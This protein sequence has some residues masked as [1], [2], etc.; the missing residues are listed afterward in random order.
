MDIISK[1]LVDIKLQ[2]IQLTSCNDV[3]TANILQCDS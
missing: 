3:H 2:E 1:K